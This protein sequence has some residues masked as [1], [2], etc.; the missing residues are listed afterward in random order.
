[1]KQKTSLV[2]IEQ[3]IMLLIL[4]A[5]AALCLRGFV[6][7]ESQSLRNTQRDAALTQL[8]SAAEVLKYHKGDFASASLS[9]G[10]LVADGQWQLSFDE[11]WKQTTQ[12]GTYRLS[13]APVDTQSP[14]LGGAALQLFRQDNT[15]LAELTIYWQEEQP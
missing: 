4:A 3:A 1:M 13:A 11:N 8:Q 14:Y 6:W 7:S 5:A 12:S 15:L 10:G 9:Y 2:L